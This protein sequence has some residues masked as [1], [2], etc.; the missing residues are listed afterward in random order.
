MRL[1][2]EF[3]HVSYPIH[4]SE[5]GV[6]V[7]PTYLALEF[8]P[9]PVILVTNPIVFELYGKALLKALK[10]K[11]FA[12]HLILIPDGEAHKTPATYFQLVEEL[13][14]LRIDRSTPLV[15]LGG[16]VTGD[17]A[18][19]AAAT[20]LRGLPLIQ[21]PTTL[22]AMVDSAVGGKVGVNTAAGKTI[23]IPPTTL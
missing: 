2:V 13:D 5:A 16:G 20:V 19:F 1:N 6:E 9:G 15:A 14:A 23:D 10:S 17:I 18:G 7:V 11:G 4:I 8:N 12:P 3:P 21:V 22:L